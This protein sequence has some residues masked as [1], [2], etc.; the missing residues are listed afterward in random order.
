MAFLIVLKDN[1]IKIM[2]EKKPSDMIVDGVLNYGVEVGRFLFE[3]ERTTVYV[4]S[5]FPHIGASDAFMVYQISKE[6]YDRL[7]AMSCQNRMP[8][9]PVSADV[10][11]AC[12]REF[13]CGESAYCLRNRCTLKDVDLSLAETD[14]NGR[15]TGCKEEE[16]FVNHFVK[17]NRRERLLFELSR[18]DKRYRGLSRFC[19]QAKEL[20]D[21]ERI[22]MKGDNLECRDDFQRFMEKYD[23]LCFVMSPDP[24]IDK[25]YLSLKEAVIQALSGTDAVIIIGNGFALVISEAMKRREKYLL[26]AE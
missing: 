22:L 2:E 19:H 20:L 21:P 4:I 17:K 23:E 12:H 9:L 10:T 1:S 3:E 11:D 13:L 14:E 24:Y 8:D 25:V 6:D 18:P 5:D 15:K 26:S 16:Y 7:L